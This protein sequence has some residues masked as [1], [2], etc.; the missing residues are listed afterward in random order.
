[1][2]RDY[3]NPFASS[4]EEI[5]QEDIPVEGAI[6]ESTLRNYIRTL[7]IESNEATVKQEAKSLVNMLFSEIEK[8]WTAWKASWGSI[9]R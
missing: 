2:K 3:E 6:M 9:P 7:L 1:M 5:G 8:F 4:E